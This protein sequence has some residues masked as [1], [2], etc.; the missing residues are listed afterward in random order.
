MYKIHTLYMCKVCRDRWCGNSAKWEV[1]YLRHTC[2]SVISRVINLFA[3]RSVFEFVM[4]LGERAC[5]AHSP[6]PLLTY[7]QLDIF[8][9]NVNR[10]Y[11]PF[12][13]KVQISLRASRL[14]PS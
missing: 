12:S 10:G 2:R 4:E 9:G 7:I 11:L 14:V 6:Q 3:P 5:L 8:D 13:N 1:S